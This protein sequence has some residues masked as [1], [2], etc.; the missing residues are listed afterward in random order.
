MVEIN[1]PL[2]GRSRSKDVQQLKIIQ[3][4][5]DWQWNVF[6]HYKFGNR[7][8]SIANCVVID[9]FFIDI[10]LVTESILSPIVWRLMFFG[11]HTQYVNENRSSFSR[12]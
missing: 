3:L 1:P 4:P 6:S 8:H 11:C 5:H 7:K 10:S 9:F 12:L 2:I